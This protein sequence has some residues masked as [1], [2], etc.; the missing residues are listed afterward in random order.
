MTRTRINATSRWHD[1][2]AWL[3]SRK[4]RIARSVRADLGVPE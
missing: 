4:G 2:I 1:L 3:V